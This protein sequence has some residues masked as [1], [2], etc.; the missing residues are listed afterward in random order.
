MKEKYPVEPFTPQNIATKYDNEKKRFRAWKTLTS[1]TG[2]TIDPVTGIPQAPDS[3]WEDFFRRHDTIPPKLLWLKDRSI[4]DINVY[5][6]VFFRETAT[7][8][9]L[10]D[11][12]ES[13]LVESDD[14][15]ESDNASET[16]NARR[17]RKQSERRRRAFDPD[18]N[19]D[20]RGDL[21]DME[22]VSSSSSSTTPAPPNKRLKVTDNMLMPLRTSLISSRVQ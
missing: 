7:G 13:D 20:L 12:G 19:V 9:Y 21:G 18:E 10:R 5:Q 2:V 15:E 8:S 14:D 11:A 3:V 17:R 22:L 6:Q 16:I 1:I 4:G